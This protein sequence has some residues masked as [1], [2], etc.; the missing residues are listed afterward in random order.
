M[1]D[2]LRDWSKLTRAGI[3]FFVV[4]FAIRTIIIMVKDSAA[5]DGQAKASAPVVVRT[6]IATDDPQNP[7]YQED[8]HLTYR[9]AWSKRVYVY[10]NYLLWDTSPQTTIAIMRNDDPHDVHVVKPGDPP[11]D[12]G[13]C[14]CIRF[15]TLGY[16]TTVNVSR[17]PHPSY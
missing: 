6:M 8:I 9:G 2:W 1:K 15:M 14:R 10:P 16:Q 5:S 12:V 4:I 13:N 3:I 11:Y 7:N 17:P